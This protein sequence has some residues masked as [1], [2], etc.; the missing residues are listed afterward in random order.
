MLKKTII[1]LLLCSGLTLVIPTQ[2]NA[3][4][5]VKA[6]SIALDGQKDGRLTIYWDVRC[7]EISASAGYR[8]EEVDVLGLSGVQELR[9][10]FLA[11]G[12]WTFS[13]DKSL[14]TYSASVWAEDK[15]G[16]VYSNVITIGSPFIAIPTPI[17]VSPNTTVSVTTTTDSPVTTIQETTTTWESTT[18]STTSTT[19]TTTIAPSTTVPVTTAPTTTMPQITTTTVKPNIPLVLIENQNVTSK[20]TKNNPVLK[21]KKLIPKKKKLI[22]NQR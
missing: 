20:F 18:T 13:V 6:N 16:R 14:P 2:A 15:D 9:G 3:Q 1:T 10:Y 7:T 19:S 17:T 4:C 22:T 12:G 11:D 21:N 5:S 8:Y